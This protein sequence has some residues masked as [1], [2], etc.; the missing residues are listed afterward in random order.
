MA[1]AWISGPSIRER[2]TVDGSSGP[3]A[4]HAGG[5]QSNCDI[6]DQSRPPEGSLPFIATCRNGDLSR[7]LALLNPRRGRTTAGDNPN[8]ALGL[9]G[10]CEHDK[11]CN[12]FMAHAVATL[13]LHRHFEGFARR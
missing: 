12:Y 11:S 7:R 5:R 1:V 8:A 3:V 13:A 2:R 4:R 10:V 6:S 9:S